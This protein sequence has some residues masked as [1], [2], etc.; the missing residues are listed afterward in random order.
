[1]E[2][3]LA[4]LS[5]TNTKR[6]AQSN[7]GRYVKHGKALG[8]KAIDPIDGDSQQEENKHAR[9]CSALFNNGASARI[10]AKVCGDAE[11]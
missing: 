10:S 7:T 3:R 6:K 8:N 2:C 5:Q 9:I 1:M 11:Q 4:W